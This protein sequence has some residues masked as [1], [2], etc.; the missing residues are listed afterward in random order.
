MGEWLLELFGA[1]LDLVGA[2][3]SNDEEENK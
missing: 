3:V 1:I 2:I